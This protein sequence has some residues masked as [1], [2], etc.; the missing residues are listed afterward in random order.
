MRRFSL[1]LAL[2]LIGSGACAQ[3]SIYRGVDAQGRVVYSDSSK[4]VQGA[5]KVEL[6]S[7]PVSVE[8]FATTA[9]PEPQTTPSAASARAKAELARREIQWEAE[10]ELAAAKR[11]Q[12]EG[13][14]PLE[15]ER[16]G[17]AGGASRLAPAY[18]ARQER[19]ARAVAAAEAAL[20]QAS[21]R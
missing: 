4:G 6:A 13:V 11:Q 9:A 20:A 18:F 17:T 19:L 7:P 14:E 3:E 12:A 5:K 16:L 10:R 15:G 2:S 1:L 8:S 21:S